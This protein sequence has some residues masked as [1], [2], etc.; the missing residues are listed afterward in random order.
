MKLAF[1]LS[2]ATAVASLLP[3]VAFAAPIAQPATEAFVTA[4]KDL[5]QLGKRQIIPFAGCDM[6]FDCYSRTL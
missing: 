4:P 6:A 3:Q 1:T 5:Q 2:A